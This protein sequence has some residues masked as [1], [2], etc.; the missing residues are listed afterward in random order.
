MEPLSTDTRLIRTP[1]YNRKFRLPRQKAYI[2]SQTADIF[3]CLQPESQIP[4]CRQSRRADTVHLRTVYLA[5]IS[6]AR[7][8][9]ESIAHSAFRFMGY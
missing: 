6:R 8:G 7:M 3:L 9:S 1:L 5:I 2:F 4:I